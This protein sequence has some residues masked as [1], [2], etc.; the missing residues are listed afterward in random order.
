[1]IGK[2][3]AAAE[4]LRRREARRGLAAYINYTNPAYVNSTFSNHVCAALDKF[5]TDMHAGVRPILILQAPPQ[6]GKSEIVSRKLPAYLLGKFPSWRIAAASYSATLADSMSLDVRRNLVS[7]EHLRLF[8]ALD[9]KRKYTIDRN[10]EFSSPTGSGSYIGDGVGGGFTGKSADV[11]IVDDPIKNAQEA[12]SS[13]TKEGHWNWYQSTCK[14]RMSAN[15]GQIIMATSWAEDDLPAR[16]VA[17]HK[18]DSRLTVL[19]FPAINEPT[20]SGY[21]PKLPRGPLVPELHPLAQLLEFKAELSDYWWSAMFQQTPK[22][23]GGNIFKEDG[24]RYYLPK[25]LPAKFDKV[26][27]SWDLTFK[28]T[29]GTDFVVGQVWGKLGANSYLLAQ[30]RARMSFTK[31]VKEVVALRDAWPRTREVLIEDKANGPAVIDTLKAS[32]PGIIPIEPDG[33]KLA[34]AHAVTSYWEAGNVW[35]PH[36]DLFPWVKDLIAELTAFPASANDDQVDALTQA[37]R[38]LYPLFNKI[39]I[40]QEAINKAMG[41]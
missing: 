10:G 9:I 18:G 7:P 29:D 1:M 8:P 25:D 26:V 3:E 23:L 28:D 5:V 34:R 6:H 22:S 24:I 35:L 38:R 2:K 32:V 4:L 17:L 36:P 21:N 16:I 19:R 31:T 37:L 14:T 30:V 27:A 33:S 15:S 40:T 12:L 11:F 39:K 13:T 41:R 20:E